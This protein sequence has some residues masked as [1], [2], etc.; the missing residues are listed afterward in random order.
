ML[1]DLFIGL[2]IIGT[3]GSLLLWSINTKKGLYPSSILGVLLVLA[4]V[5][6]LCG[7]I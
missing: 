2:L 1:G 3:F 7:F 5:L 6:S 4:V